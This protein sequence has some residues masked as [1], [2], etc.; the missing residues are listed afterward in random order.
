MEGDKFLL[1]QNDIQEWIHFHFPF[2]ETN[3]YS[4]N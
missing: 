1:H 2:V 4:E 3:I